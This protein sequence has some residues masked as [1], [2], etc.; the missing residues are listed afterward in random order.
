MIHS[1]AFLSL[2]RATP[3]TVSLEARIE[4]WRSRLLD[5]SRRNRLISL[6]LGRAGAV[7]LVHPAS[8]TLWS[9]LVDEGASVSFPR[10]L[11]LVGKAAEAM[12]EDEAKEFPSLLDPGTEEKSHPDKLELQTYLAS[13]R[14]RPEH[15]SDRTHGQAAQVTPWSACSQ[16]Q[17]FSDRAGRTHP[18]RRVRAAQVVRVAR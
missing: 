15:V 11:Y 1:P 6:S 10:K 14:L 7:K 3:M 16:R 13:P 9:N 8:D 18:L 4:E 5:T 12:I 17:D 2:R